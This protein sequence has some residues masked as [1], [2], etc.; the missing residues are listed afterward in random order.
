[1]TA[2][3]KPIGSNTFEVLERVRWSDCDPL[4]IIHHG[5]YVRLI[6]VGE[7]EMFRACGL[8]FERLRLQKGVWLPRKALHMEFHSPAQMDEEV[9]VQAWIPKIGTTSLTM[10]FEVLRASDRVSRA[11][12]T[13]TV[14][15]VDKETMKKRPIPDDVRQALSA[16][17]R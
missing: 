9:V 7:H 3:D 14:V 1:V 5:A 16:Y 15:C 11:S 17:A 2:H 12:A 4:G 8:P 13:L 10:N 6:E